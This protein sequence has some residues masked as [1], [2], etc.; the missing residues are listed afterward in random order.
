MGQEKYTIHTKVVE[1]F[2]SSK[3]YIFLIWRRRVDE[4]IN[5]HFRDRIIRDRILGI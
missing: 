4:K 5:K 2:I 1:D 3:A